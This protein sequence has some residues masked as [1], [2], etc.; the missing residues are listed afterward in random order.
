MQHSTK[1]TVKIARKRRT[2][3]LITPQSFAKLFRGKFEMNFKSGTFYCGFKSED[4]NAHAWGISPVKA[5]RNMLRN[6]HQKYA[7]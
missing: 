3:K 7:V 5:Y 4:R 6:F 2:R 1:S